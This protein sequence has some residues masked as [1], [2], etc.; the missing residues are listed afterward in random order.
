MSQ[1]LPRSLREPIAALWRALTGD[2]PSRSTRSASGQSHRTDG[3]QAD[4]REC[5][6]AACQ[7]DHVAD[8][9]DGAG[10]TEIWEYL[11][12]REEDDAADG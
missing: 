6:R 12:E 8:V 1:R 4:G 5:S 10:C 7:H 2:L 11:S 3:G 9:P